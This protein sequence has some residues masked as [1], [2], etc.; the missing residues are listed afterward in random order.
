[1]DVD[2]GVSYIFIQLERASS[3]YPGVIYQTF[4]HSKNMNSW[5]YT[6][7][8]NYIFILFSHTNWLLKFQLLLAS[9]INWIHL[10]LD[11]SFI[12]EEVQRIF[13][14]VRANADFMPQWQVKVFLVY[15]LIGLFSFRSSTVCLFICPVY[16]SVSLM[17]WIKLLVLFACLCSSPVPLRNEN[18]VKPSI[19]KYVLYLT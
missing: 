6:F 5:K 2:N 14:R 4:P 3:I 11:N 16:Q 10:I 8:Y 15:E 13:D 12:P 7:H 17:C 19:V 1:M 9:S 18:D